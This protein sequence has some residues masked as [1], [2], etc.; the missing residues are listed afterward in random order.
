MVAL[1]LHSAEKRPNLCRT[2]LKLEV[3]ILS[4]TVVH[5]GFLPLVLSHP[6]G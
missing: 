5:L 6:R 2:N 4:L 1:E 3:M